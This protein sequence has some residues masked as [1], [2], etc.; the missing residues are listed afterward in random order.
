MLPY[1]HPFRKIKRLHGRGKGEAVN[2]NAYI[3]NTLA[4]D[5]DRLCP[6][7]ENKALYVHRQTGRK[8]ICQRLPAGAS[9]AVFTRL[10]GVENR[11]VA[12]VLDV[13]E[14]GDGFLVLIQYVPGETLAKRLK[15]TPRF[16]RKAVRAVALDL[17]DALMELHGLGVAH[18]DLKP[19][20]VILDEKGRATLIDLGIATVIDEG[21][22]QKTAALGTVG[23]AAPEQFGMSRT[24]AR[25]D[26]FAWGVVIN[27]MLTHAHPTVERYR[28]GKWGRILKK[29]LA[30][31]P[32]DRYQSARALKEAILAPW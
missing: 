12:R 5:Y 28:R 8:L 7:G 10:A 17:C 11:R 1:I 27:L 25:T 20:N 19:E 31:A 16:P 9:P 24:D 22:S 13:A 14:D 3:L 4:K 6:L 15:E 21:R 2:E 29:C 32:S 23:F 18:K 30:T 26:L